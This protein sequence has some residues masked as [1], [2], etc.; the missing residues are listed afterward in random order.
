MNRSVLEVGGGILV[1]SQFTLLGDVR[2]GKRP[3]FSSAAEPHRAQELYTSYCC[4]IAALGIQVEQGRF[5]TDMQVSLVN[6]G[7]VTILL[8]STK[9]F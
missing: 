6:S 3:S 1:V 7:P 5:Q 9:L 2:R 8:D 4:R